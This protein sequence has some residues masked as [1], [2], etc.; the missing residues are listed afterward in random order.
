[1]GAVKYRTVDADGRKI[2]YREAGVPLHQL[3]PL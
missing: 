2:F 3:K 1:M